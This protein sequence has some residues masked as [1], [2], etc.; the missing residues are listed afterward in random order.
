MP[1]CPLWSSAHAFPRQTLSN[2]TVEN[3]F[4]QIKSKY[5]AGQRLTY[6]EFVAER[7]SALQNL[8]PI[9]VIFKHCIQSLNKNGSLKLFIKQL[10]KIG[11]TSKAPKKM[12]SVDLDNLSL[13]EEQWQRRPEKK[14]KYI[15]LPSKL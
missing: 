8:L 2:A 4:R 11:I 10:A 6:S 15:K 14:R 1:F 5:R 7:Y 3:N 9:L 13:V 12:K